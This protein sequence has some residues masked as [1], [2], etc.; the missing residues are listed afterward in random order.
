[1]SSS[2]VPTLQGC[3]VCIKQRILWSREVLSILLVWCVCMT[4]S[5]THINTEENCVQIESKLYY[6]SLVEIKL[7]QIWTHR[8]Q[9]EK[10]CW[11]L[12]WIVS[13]LTFSM[14][15]VFG[16]PHCPYIWLWTA[17]TDSHVGREGDPP[18]SKRNPFHVIPPI[19]HTQFAVQL[20]N[21]RC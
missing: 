12:I 7:T 19:T 3:V 8:S 6:S 1:M 5:L 18:T 15:T 14:P 21:A 13:S 4:E 9:F 10:N 11:H 17:F 2:E 20:A 16:H